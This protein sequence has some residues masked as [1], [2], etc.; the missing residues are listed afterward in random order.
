MGLSSNEV[1]N[2]K[3]DCSH[4]GKTYSVG[5]QFYDNC[6]EFCMCI[7]GSMGSP[8]LICNPIKCPS[9]FGLDVINPFCLKWDEH[10]DFVAKPPMCCPPLPVCLSDG[11]CEYH[12]QK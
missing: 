8:E 12:G 3:G 4:N 2:K 10:S 1:S 6:D 5:E 7:A 9:S 11:T